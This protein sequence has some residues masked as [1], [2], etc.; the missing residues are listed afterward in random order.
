MAD[1]WLAETYIQDSQ[2]AGDAHAGQ[3]QDSL[4]E[5]LSEDEDALY[6]QF[7][8]E[9]EASMKQGVPAQ[10]QAQVMYGGGYNG[11]AVG[12]WR[13]C[14]TSTESVAALGQQPLWM[15]IVPAWHVPAHSKAGRSMRCYESPFCRPA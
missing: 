12:K 9:E 10:D 1:D 5:D 11:G 4:E 6:Q 2:D 8:R 7:L 3:Q 15:P 13:P 14:P